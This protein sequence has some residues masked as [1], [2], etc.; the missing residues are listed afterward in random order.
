M[1]E[2]RGEKKKKRYNKARRFFLNQELTKPFLGSKY[3]TSLFFFY[4]KKKKQPKS[5]NYGIYTKY[6]YCLTEQCLETNAR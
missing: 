3:G 1:V 4:S 5:R 2:N 6:G